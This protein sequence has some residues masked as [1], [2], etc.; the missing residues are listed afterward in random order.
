MLLQ[1]LAAYAD[2]YLGQQLSDPAFEDKGIRYSLEIDERGKFIRISERVTEI[3]RGNRT[4]QRVEAL[5][6]PKSPVNRNNPNVIHPLLGC[7]AVQYLLGPMAGVWTN[8]GE[9]SNHSAHHSGFVKLMNDASGQTGDPALVACSLFLSDKGEMERARADLAQKKPTRGALVTL[10]VRPSAIDSED[11]GG[12]VV[13]REATRQ[14]WRELYSAKFNQ[15][16]STGG[17]GMCLISGSVGPIAATHNPIRGVSGLGGRSQVLLMSFDKES[18]RSYGWKKNANSPVSPNRATAYVLTLNDLLRHGEHRQGRSPD[19]LVRTRSDSDFG[20][21]AFIYW[22]RKPA[23]EDP[24]SYFYNPQPDHIASLIRSPYTGNQNSVGVQANSFYLLAVSGNGARLV[25]RDWFYDSLENVL[26]SIGDWFD[27]L[28]VA[29]VFNGGEPSKAPRLFDILRAISPPGVKPDDK[30]NAQYTMQI[31][32]RALQGIPFGYSILAAALR[33]LHVASGSNRLD[34]VRVGL[35]KMC[36]ND[37]L[38]TKEG[39]PL[40]G[41]SLDPTLEAPAYTCGRLLAVYEGLQYQAQGE[42]N[43]SIA[44]RYYS[45][46]STYPQLA[47]PKIEALSKAH[48]KKLRRENAPAAYAIANRLAHLTEKLIPYGAKYPAQLNLEDQ[49]R[50]VI[51]YH[52]Q[53]AEDARKRKE[54]GER[55]AAS[56]SVSTD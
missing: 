41:E 34:P 50:F 15:R 7:D 38:T 16:H 3:T 18:F 20:G 29:D 53:K 37:I 30:V 27:G 9:E 21:V 45:L 46:A 13:L 22:T 32:R 19:K 1:A 26:K 52:H 4:V 47:F 36:V 28:S 2:T 12:A 39:G 40:M 35:I 42:L 44:D 17:H 23:D 14:F 10:T 56:E 54:A 11:P 48:L 33:R 6:V 8:A 49:G 55:K 25:I 43:V 5:S 24:M 51:G 31:V